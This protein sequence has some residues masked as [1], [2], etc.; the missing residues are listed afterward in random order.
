MKKKISHRA[1]VALTK[2]MIGLP[3]NHSWQ[4]HGFTIFLEFGELSYDEGRNNPQGE[5]SL[6]LD[7]TWRIE[8]SR[9][10]LVGSFSTDTRLKNNLKK[11]IGHRAT[12]VELFG[13]LPE[14]TVTLDSNLRVVSF[15]TYETQPDWTLF[16]PDRSWIHCRNGWLTQEGEEPAA[17]GE[18]G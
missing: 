6:M 10:I 5:Y 8:K 4:G 12:G 7:C 1:F 16:L 17:D 14:I 18:R 11:L 2:S 9:S 15:A 3:I 13:V